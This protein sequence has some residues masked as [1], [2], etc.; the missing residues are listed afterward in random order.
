MGKGSPFNE[1]PTL[2]PSQRSRAEACLDAVGRASAWHGQ[3]PVL[4][5]NRC[6]LRLTVV[7][8][9]RLALELPPDL[10]RA[11]PELERYRALVE[12]GHSAWQAQQLCWL[13]F[14]AEACQQALRRFWTAQERHR[15]GWSLERYLDLLNDYRERFASERPRPIPLIVLSRP[16]RGD[17]AASARGDGAASARD[18]HGLFWLRPGLLISE[19]AMRHTC[20]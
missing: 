1:L 8:V 9:E 19:R 18:G 15:C 7:P 16:A 5:L 14:G 10:S 2:T 11:A 6:W 3:L 12:A 13:E 20:A 4:L 17:G